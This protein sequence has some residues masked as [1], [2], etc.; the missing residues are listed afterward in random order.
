MIETLPEGRFLIP[1]DQLDSYP[2]YRQVWDGGA[3]L[4]LYLLEQPQTV[5]GKSVL[6]VGTGS[7]IVLRMAYLLGAAVLAIDTDQ[8]AVEY[9]NRTLPGVHAFTATAERWASDPSSR[10]QVVLAGDLFYSPKVAASIQPALRKWRSRG[11]EV[12]AG[13]PGRPDFPLDEYEKVAE[14]PPASV[15]RMK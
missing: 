9:V 1:D 6:D 14:Y 4:V 11:A 7:G 8:E 5:K 10:P 15:Y 3:A 13:D 12:Y 2:F